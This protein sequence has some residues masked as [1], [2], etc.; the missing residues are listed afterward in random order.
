VGGVTT[1]GLTTNGNILLNYTSTNCTGTPYMEASQIPTLG[2]P[3]D[4][5]NPNGGTGHTTAIIY[6]PTI[7]Y[8]LLTIAPAQNL[9]GPCNS[10][11]PPY[12][13]TNMGAAATV[14]LTVVRPLSIQ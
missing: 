11:I 10:F 12:Q 2:F 3:Y 8:Q 6:Y 7:P 4:P 14:P 5:A 13:I 1:N 9:G